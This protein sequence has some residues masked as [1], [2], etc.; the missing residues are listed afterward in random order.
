M[1]TKKFTNIIAILSLTLLLGATAFGQ[2]SLTNAAPSQTIDFSTTVAGVNNAIYNGTGLTPTPAA[3]QLDSDAFEILGF[4]D[5]PL[6]FGGTGTTGDFARGA[7]A[8]GVTSGGLYAYSTNPA[9]YVQSTGTDFNP[10]TITLRI[11]NNGTTNINSLTVSY[12][13]L[14]LNDQA[15]SSSFNFAHSS[16]NTTFTPVPAAD[17]TS[18]T[19]ADP[20]P[21]V[22]TVVRGPIN[23]TG[24]TIAPGGFFYLR[25]RSAD[26]AGAGSRDEFGLDNIAVTATFAA[27][28]TAGEVSVSGRVMDNRGMPIAN[29]TVFLSG[30]PL[31][32]SRR[33][34]TG[35]FGVFRFN[36]VSVGTTYVISVMNGTHN[37]DQPSLIINLTDEE[38]GLLFTGTRFFGSE[39]D[40]KMKSGGEKQKRRF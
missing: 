19:T 14:V 31:T 39:G 1:T 17:Y 26:V 21:A 12:D 15:R 25:Y 3:G 24:L 10:G 27:I 4:S 2:L 34:T 36:T 20:A 37:F 6:N 30:G 28:P 23:I 22:V 11:Q 16:D 32:Q 35:S 38:N 8:G 29:A 13:I 7:T 33:V 18:P 9:I 5:G 40:Q